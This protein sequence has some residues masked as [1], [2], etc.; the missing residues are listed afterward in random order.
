MKC[1]LEEEDLQFIVEAAK[2]NVKNHK[3]HAYN[4]SERGAD[5]QEI[6]IMFGHVA[7]LERA[8]ESAQKTIDKSYFK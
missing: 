3:E 8:L 5:P 7:R 6:T 4:M 1:E 2:E